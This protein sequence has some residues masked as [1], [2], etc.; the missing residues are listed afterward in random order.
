MTVATRRPLMPATGLP[1]RSQGHD[2]G[3]PGAPPSLS[4]TCREDVAP[5]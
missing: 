5:G 3:R 4:G 1:P 2:M